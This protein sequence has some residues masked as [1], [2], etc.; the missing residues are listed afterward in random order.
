MWHEHWDRIVIPHQ[1]S[2]ARMDSPWV[3]RLGYENVDTPSIEPG[4]ARVARKLLQADAGI[5][6]CMPRNATHTHIGAGHE[7]EVI[8]CKGLRKKGSPD[9]VLEVPAVEGS[10]SYAAEPDERPNHQAQGL[11]PSANGIGRAPELA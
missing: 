5:V 3:G 1:E 11:E 10:Q 8:G 2:R 6:H 4:I 9:E 7:R